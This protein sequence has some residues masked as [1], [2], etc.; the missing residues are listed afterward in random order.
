MVKLDN[1][2]QAEKYRSIKKVNF[3]YDF[4]GKEIVYMQDIGLKCDIKNS[5]FTLDYESYNVIAKKIQEYQANKRIQLKYAEFNWPVGKKETSSLTRNFNIYALMLLFENF[6]ISARIHFHNLKSIEIRIFT[7]ISNIY[8]HYKSI[9]HIYLINSELKF[10]IN[11][12]IVKNCADTRSASNRSIKIFSLFQIPLIENEKDFFFFGCRFSIRLCPLIFSNSYIK[13]FKIFDLVDTF[14]KTNLMKF[15]NLSIGYLNSNIMTIDIFRCENIVLDTSFLNPSVFMKLEKIFIICDLK[16]ISSDLFLSLKNLRKIS[17]QTIHFRKFIHRNGIEWMK[18]FN[19]GLHVNLS[20]ITDFLRNL[21]K[22]KILILRS[23]R[24]SYIEPM[25]KVFPEE[26]FCIYK[27]YPFDQMVFTYQQA[28]ECKNNETCEF[29]KIINPSY[30]CTYLWINQYYHLFRYT[31][32]SDSIKNNLFVFLNSN[33]YKNRN[34]CDFK[35]RLSL[36]NQ[37]DFHL[38]S[39]WGPHDFFILNKKI[40]ISVKILTYLVSLFSIVTN[41]LVIRIIFAK[42]NKHVFK[43]FKHYT[44]LGLI[45]I[46]SL[47]ISMIEILAWLSECFYPFQVFCL[48]VHKTV[49]A[50]LFKM[51]FKESIVITLRFMSN[52][53]YI[54]FAFCRI[55][56]ISQNN[57]A[58][59]K[60]LSK[61]PIWK[62]ALFSLVISL[63]FSWIKYFKYSINFSQGELNYPIW[64]ERDI[65]TLG[66]DLPGILDFYMVFNVISDLLNYLV[67][68]IVSF[69]VDL[70]M[71]VKLRST[72]NESLERI[73]KM[74]SNDKQMEKKK[75]DLEETMKKSIRMVVLNTSIGLVF[76]LPL[77]FLPLV[78]T[79]AK[80]YY[81]DH[82]NR[83]RNLD[84]DHFYALLFESDFYVLIHDSTELLYLISVT[85][86]FFIY[87]TFDKKFKEATFSPLP[88]KDKNCQ[89]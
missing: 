34:N 41:I 21:K 85:I 16:S 24:G 8:K 14:F 11:G 81:K 77:V 48:G 35:R 10:T 23:H 5:N 9:E 7:N 30:S 38:K 63:T 78:N 49:V 18:A 82:N 55:S 66:A 68:V 71:L 31:S 2:N 17:F 64:N 70:A 25:S 13:G 73:K 20:D 74:G 3:L 12:K 33:S 67:F 57:G 72:V 46:F 65:S 75:S 58:F 15:E 56:L 60:F 87:K 47:S 42:H 27:E 29:L 22:L 54:A 61:L 6:D 76:K 88:D 52:L 84:F 69:C 26:D 59:I 40:H 79:I 50:Q 45:S 80:F 32:A 83:Y 43:D 62:Y 44:Y 36:C 39:I 4:L 86:Q 1:K 19:R 51:I 53:C 28:N 37:S 89:K